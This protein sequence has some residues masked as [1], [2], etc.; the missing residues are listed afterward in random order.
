MEVIFGDPIAERWFSRESLGELISGRRCPLP[1]LDYKMEYPP[2][3]GALWALSTCLPFGALAV[4]GIR[5]F[6]VATLAHLL[7]YHY[8]V[9]GAVISAAFLAS[10]VLAT[11]LADALGVGRRRI[12]FFLLLPSTTLYLVYN[13]DALALVFM[14][15]SLYAFVRGRFF[16]SGLALG[17]AASAKVLPVVAGA[18][19]LAALAS[20]GRGS[21][22]LM[23]V[24]RLVVGGMVGVSPYLILMAVAPTGLLWS[25]DYVSG[26]ICENCIYELFTQDVFSPANRYLA[27]VMVV[28]CAI[29]S[30]VAA[31]RRR[32][33]VSPATVCVLGAVS[34]NYIFTPQMMLLLT[35]LLALVLPT[36]RLAAVV[37]A[38]ASN[39]LIVPL[40]GVL[41]QATEALRALGLQ[42]VPMAFHPASPVQLVATVRNVALL[43]VL[44]LEG[45]RLLR[46]G[47]ATS[48]GA[49]DGWVGD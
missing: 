27:A 24:A 26:W 3:V 41:E 12:L 1:Y 39:F 9:Q 28:A 36:R 23:D 48:A 5:A 11:R 49:E 46:A 29:V 47:R 34:L 18:P 33:A 4:G 32:E 10:V 13:Y 43:A 19:M 30:S 40:I 21:G 37:V 15:A 2:L 44:V 16:L 17:L 6:D 35:P 38:D 25:F 31:A 7:H 14:L 20:R 42:A 22:R 8:V 45:E